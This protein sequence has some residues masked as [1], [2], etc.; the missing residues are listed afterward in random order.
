MPASPNLPAIDRLAPADVGLLA[1]LASMWGLSFLFIAVAVT[2]LSPLWI[3]TARTAVGV[4]TLSAILAVRGRKLPRDLSSWGHLVVL[5]LLSNAVP[6]TAIAFA[7][8]SIPSGTAAL[9]MAL[10]PISTLAMG[11]VLR[12]ERLTPDRVAGLLVALAGVAAIVMGD[13]DDP[14][15]LIGIATIIGVTIVYSLGGLYARHFLSGWHRP[16]VIATGQVIV[17]GLMTLPAALLFAPRPDMAAIDGAVVTSIVALGALGTGL[18]FLAFYMLIERVGP[19]NAAL[20]NYL[21]PLVA[22][23][24]GWV[25]L[26]ERLHPAAIVGGFLV[27]A[28]IWLSQRRRPSEMIVELEQDHR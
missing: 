24:A 3:V 11:A 26:D 12:L 1:A 21:I 20:V 8:Q 14:G 27:V 7:L 15:R 16:L 18:A 2:A 19:T 13:I 17:A 9:L 23:I 25:V 28:G 5:G 4:T 10:I 6:W 22:V